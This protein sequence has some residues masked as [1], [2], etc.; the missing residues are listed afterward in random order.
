MRLYVM[1]F[2][3]Y[4]AKNS[5]IFRLYHCHYYH[6]SPFFPPVIAIAVTHPFSPPVIAII[7]THLYFL[8]LSLLLLSPILFSP[9]IIAIAANPFFF[10]YFCPVSTNLPP[11][12]TPRM[13]LQQLE[14]D[15]RRLT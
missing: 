12:N 5:A 10:S 2:L 7:A 8:S 9:P 13:E 6:P 14:T 1:A 11:V 15:K 4:S 3:S